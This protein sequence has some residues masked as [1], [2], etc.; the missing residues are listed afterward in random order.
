M[1]YI[2]F[3]VREYLHI[4]Y[5]SIATISCIETML[6]NCG[7]VSFSGAYD[8]HVLMLIFLVMGFVFGSAYIFFEYRYRYE[9][10]HA[11]SI[12]NLCTCFFADIN[13]DSP[14][15]ELQE[16]YKRVQSIC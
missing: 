11:Y 14:N 3:F 13:D 9:T 4:L 16:K 1:R 8:F 6:A 7:I 2:L 15:V 5:A 12:L 10:S